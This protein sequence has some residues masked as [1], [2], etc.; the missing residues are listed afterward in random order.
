M[1]SVWLAHRSDGRFEGRAAIKFLNLALIARGGAERFSREGQVLAKLSH[2]NI[3]R[4][5]DAGI[6]SGSQPYL[7]LEYVDGEP[8]DRWCEAHALDLEARIRLFLDVLGAVDYAH[9]NLILHRDLK[10]ANI[11]VTPGRRRETPRFRHR[12]ALGRP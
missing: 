8:I 3:A 2:P 11:L 6:A 4:L 5:L 1:G 7:V 10:P 12:E 9:S